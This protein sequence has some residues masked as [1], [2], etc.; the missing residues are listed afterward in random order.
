MNIKRIEL[1]NFK[2][3]EKFESEFSGGVYLVTGENE[4][5]K[6]TLL[7]AIST[8]LTGDRTS[9]LL[10]QGK[11]KGHAKIEVGEGENMY[12]VELKFTEKNPRGNLSITH[13]NGMKSDNK[14]MLQTV[15]KYHDFDANEF[16]SW[17][18]TSEGRKKQ[19]ELVKSILSKEDQERL[20]QIEL[21]HK[22]AYDERKDVNSNVKA[23]ASRLRDYTDEERSKYSEKLDIVKLLEEK[24]SIDSKN[25][26]IQSIQERHQERSKLIESKKEELD[27]LQFEINSLKETQEKA[28]K[29]IES[30]L[31]NPTD[32]LVE[33]IASVQHHNEKNSEINISN[34]AKEVHDGFVKKQDELKTTLDSLQVEKTSIISGSELPI[35]GLTFTDDGLFLNGIPFAPGEVST[36][37]QMEV[38][39]KLVIA[40]NPTV[41]VF[42]IAQG[43]SLGSERLKAIIDFA[44]KNGY[45]GFIENMIRDQKELIVEEYVEK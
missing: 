13:A 29:W 20:V 40:K 14:S 31:I 25:N 38:A 27:A 33:K 9:N 32:D 45:Q 44:K 1:Q 21:D 28:E 18:K 17:S 10:Q 43:E 16:V 42:R 7:G 8:L 37:Q 12:T 6:S 15:F 30:N 35:E 24:S 2:T 4:I 36:S 23:A 11:E 26:E 39:A 34:Q 41:K 5:G 19:V 3:I 22:A